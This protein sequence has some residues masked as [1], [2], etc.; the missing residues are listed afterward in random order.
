MRKCVNAYAPVYIYQYT[1][2]GD[3]AAVPISEVVDAVIADLQYAVQLLT[4][5]E[6]TALAVSIGATAIL[7]DQ[8]CPSIDKTAFR[9]NA[10]ARGARYV[11][12][13]ISEVIVRK[14][15]VSEWTVTNGSSPFI[16]T[17]LPDISSA[18]FPQR[19]GSHVAVL[20]KPHHTLPFQAM[21]RLQPLFDGNLVLNYHVLQPILKT[22]TSE[23]DVLKL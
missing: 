16:G 19:S 5:P 18:N 14:A 10:S 17:F 7:A 11:S 4:D 8:G 12:A 21:R 1:N 9:S 22:G 15:P 3:E 23:S 6:D 13:R 2:I 20:F